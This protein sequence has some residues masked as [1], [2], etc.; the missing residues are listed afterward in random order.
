M[1]II[2]IGLG[3]NEG[4]RLRILRNAAAQLRK[5][6]GILIAS[7]S[8]YETEPWGFASEHT[9]Y[10]AVMKFET[11]HKPEEVLR[12]LQYLE[13]QAGRTR[14][15]TDHYADRS[16]DLDLL[17]Y[18]DLLSD[19]TDLQVPHPRISVRNFVLFPLH[20]TDPDWLDV[21]T[22][23]TVREMTPGVKDSGKIEK[24]H[25]TLF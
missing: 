19:A 11:E 16:L 10:N 14:S 2:F 15:D 3:S 17:Y 20:E 23:K 13:N 12:I 21:R 6:L 24:L 25:E 7:S 18:D 4:D 8:V 5:N 9:F 22:Q 1:A